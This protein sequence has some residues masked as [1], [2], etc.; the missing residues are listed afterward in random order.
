MLKSGRF[1]L[2]IL[3]SLVFLLLFFWKMDF[4]GTA[5]ALRAANYYLL[6]PAIAVYFVAVFFRSLRWRFLLQP[7]KATTTRRL[8]P[9]VVIGY[10]ANNLLP[11]RL[12]ELVRAYFLGE[13]ENISKTATLATIL[14]ERV[15]DGIIL[16]VFALIVWPFLP[17]RQLLDNFSTSTGIPVGFLVVIISAPFIIVL[18]V[19]FA[20]ALSK[21]VAVGISK[22]ILAVLP[23]KVRPKV[24]PFIERFIE[25]LAALRSPRRVLAVFVLSAPVWLAEATMY[26]IIS[27]AF[28]LSQPFHAILLSTST[29]NL[30]ITAPSTGG[31]IGPFEW[32]TKLTLTSLGAPDAAAG[33]Y[34]IVLHA[35]LLVPVTVLGLYYLWSLNL[36]LGEMTR[37][38]KWAG[39]PKAEAVAE[40]TDQK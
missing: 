39:E 5:D 19:L 40:R 32:A 23:R 30:A 20:A 33:A 28:N 16:L 36:S 2:G 29:A 37:G 10:M 24:Q 9:V 35:A 15:F 17:L 18:A 31:G 4:R 7:L 27:I 22:V 3:G 38:K 26:F 11:I 13:K 1:W 25:G 12:G 14:L 34:A 6:I 21:S 8:F